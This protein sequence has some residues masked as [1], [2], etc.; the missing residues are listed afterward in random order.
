LGDV[1]LSI[2]LSAE[3]KL[4]PGDHLPILLPEHRLSLFDATNGARL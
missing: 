3:T 2:R 4:A 1:P